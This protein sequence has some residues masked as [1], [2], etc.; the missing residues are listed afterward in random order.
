MLSHLVD[1]NHDGLV[2][3]GELGHFIE[4]QRGKKAAGGEAEKEVVKVVDQGGTKGSAEADGKTRVAAVDLLTEKLLT[5]LHN[6]KRNK[7]RHKPPRDDLR[8]AGDASRRQIPTGEYV[9]LP[10]F[11]T[12]T[13]L[14]AA[15]ARG[16]TPKWGYHGEGK[17]IMSDGY[18]ELSRKPNE[19]ARPEKTYAAMKTLKRRAIERRS[20]ASGGRVPA[21]GLVTKIGYVPNNTRPSGG[22]GFVANQVDHMSAAAMEKQQSSAARQH[23]ASRGAV[24]REGAGWTG[25][26]GLVD[27][28]TNNYERLLEIDRRL[29]RKQEEAAEDAGAADLLGEMVTGATAAT[30]EDEEALRRR[31]AEEQAEYEK[32]F[33]QKERNEATLYNEAGTMQNRKTYE[34][35]LAAR[36]G[37]EVTSE[38]LAGSG[39]YARPALPTRPINAKPSAL[40]SKPAQPARM[41]TRRGSTDASRR[42]GSGAALR[43]AV[44]GFNP[45][46]AA[47]QLSSR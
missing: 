20:K 44:G 41:R 10:R 38:Q 28:Q 31:R 30:A 29:R 43:K 3:Q 47:R 45:A 8:T 16:R 25:D 21:S 18:F 6:K 40:P 34:G 17:T 2:T 35:Q 39:F 12:R 4:N 11:R 32:A 27:K 15:R 1:T 14:M 46:A 7:P 23:E 36:E 5:N 42:R 37:Q 9:A 33:G 26:S 22:R 19:H 24:V 13:E